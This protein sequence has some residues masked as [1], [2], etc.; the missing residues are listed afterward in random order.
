MGTLDATERVGLGRTVIVGP[1]RYPALCPAGRELLVSHG[2]T[3]VENDSTLPWTAEELIARL[4]VADAAVAGVEVYDADALS[5]APRLQIISRLGVGLDNIDLD[6]ARRRGVAVVNVPGGNAGS[7]AELAIGFMLSLLRRIPEMDAAA[8]AGRWD[9]Y[10]GRELAGKTV[11]LIGFGAIAQTV[12]RR[13]RGFEVEVVAFDPY[14]DRA[15]AAA[16][17]VRLVPTLVDAVSDVDI[18]SVHAPHT[19]A[20]HHTVDD[21]LIAAMRPG[22]IV[23]NTSRGGLVDE[24]ALVRGLTSGHLA[25]AGLD[26]FEIEPATAANPL[27]A[28][29]NVVV[30]PHAAADSLEAYERIGLATARAIVDVFAGRVPAALVA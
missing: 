15:A 23:V 1:V 22:T 28:L 20:T 5:H 18:V 26:V 6:E 8:K 14:A 10:V 3:L 13:L 30:A 4:A 7:V 16:L 24:A 19:A 9:R 25:G 12:A 17:D 2:F 27:F 29:D 11:G 21:A